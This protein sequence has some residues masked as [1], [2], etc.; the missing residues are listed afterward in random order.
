MDKARGGKYDAILEGALRTFAERGYH[1]ARVSNIAKAAGVADGTIYLYFKR[2]EDILI[3]LFQEKLSGLVAD[4]RDRIAG[5]AEPRAK[6][7]GIVEAHFAALESNAALARVTQVEL[8]RCSYEMRREI[9][10]CLKPY[11]ALIEDVI[12]EGM[13]AG[14][15]RRDLNVKLTAHLL[16][17]AMDE[18][19]SAW[20][21]AGRKYALRAQ[22]DGAVRFMLG[23]LEAAKENETRG[24]EAAC[25]S[26]CC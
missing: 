18:V 14:L 16:F 15:F 4:I 5:A 22:A 2:K 13:A 9:G 12:A 11:M 25:E 23:G 10:L 3:R 7:A 26:S 24:G 17:G 21:V 20:L 1:G 8:R 19:V 6:L